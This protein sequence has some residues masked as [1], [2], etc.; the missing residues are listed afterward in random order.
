MI[1]ARKIRQNL[2]LFHE[3]SSIYA[4]ISKANNDQDHSFN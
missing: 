2:V 4:Q 3:F 1:F